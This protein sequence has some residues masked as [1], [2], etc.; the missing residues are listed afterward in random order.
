LKKKENKKKTKQKK[1]V[2]RR[3][4]GNQTVPAQLISIVWKQIL[5]K[6]MGA[7]N[8]LITGFLRKYVPLCSAEQINSYRFETTSS[9]VRKWW[10]NLNF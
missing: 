1:K 5:W 2:F 9:K 10:Q 6:A 7:I 3:I 4:F 8:C